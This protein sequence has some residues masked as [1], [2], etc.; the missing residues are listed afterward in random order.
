MKVFLS[1]GEVQQKLREHFEQ[2]GNAYSF[3]DAAR[4]LW[5][6][7][8]FRTAEELPSVAFDEWN[9]DDLDELER[10]LDRT[11]V[12]G[13]FFS[14]KA[15][16]KPEPRPAVMHTTK[17]KGVPIRIASD[18]AMGAHAHNVFRILYLLRG[19]ARLKLGSTEQVC[20]EKI[21]SA[22]LRRISTTTS[23]QTEAA[24]SSPLHCLTNSWRT[25]YISC[26]GR[27]T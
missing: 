2:T 6:E 4:E 24:W 16:P 21:R 13:S 22:L 25:P 8:K 9:V 3:F 7:G 14:R 27:I 15:Q 20:W 18:Q 12:D 23:W 26:C 1:W 17:P 19:S 11:P 5:E 10:L